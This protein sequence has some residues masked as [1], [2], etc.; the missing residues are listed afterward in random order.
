M[1]YP[2]LYGI[3]QVRL[4]YYLGGAKKMAEDLTEKTE[5]KSLSF[6]TADDLT[7]FLIDLQGQIANLTET[8]HKIKPVEEPAEEEKPE[9]ETK[10]EQ[11]EEEPTKEEV[12]KI[13]KLLQRS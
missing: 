13:D 2:F 9:E 4:K 6:E 7:D 1:T 3:I 11:V 5:E 12:S 8:V 10:E